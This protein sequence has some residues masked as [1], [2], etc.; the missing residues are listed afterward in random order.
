MSL[1]ANTS[2]FCTYLTAAYTRFSKQRTMLK[3]LRGVKESDNIFFATRLVG[4]KGRSLNLSHKLD[5]II[6]T[7]K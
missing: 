1:N 4:R 6:S 5:S 2:V 7:Y 3:L